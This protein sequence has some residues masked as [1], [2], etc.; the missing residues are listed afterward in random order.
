MKLG[1]L[2]PQIR[3]PRLKFGQHRPGLEE[4]G[5]RDGRN[6]NFMSH[7]RTSPGADKPSPFA[8]ILLGSSPAAAE[9][10]KVTRLGPRF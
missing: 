5:E 10:A 1:H 8:G 3:T 7:N 6:E 2:L 9:P 4:Q